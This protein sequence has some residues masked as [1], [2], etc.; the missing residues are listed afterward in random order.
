LAS[1]PRAWQKGRLGICFE[2]RIQDPWEGAGHQAWA[3]PDNHWRIMARQSQG[4]LLNR[5]KEVEQKEKEKPEMPA[6]S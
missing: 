1:I 2:S 3:M 4:Q 6:P 5:Q